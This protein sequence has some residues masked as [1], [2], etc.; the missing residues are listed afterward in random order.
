MVDID[1]PLV[2]T[3]PIGNVSTMAH[4]PGQRNFDW[5]KFTQR[6]DFDRRTPD[7]PTGAPSATR[8]GSALPDR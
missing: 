5:R 2:E 3:F 7:T 4:R 1:S 6:D 8:I